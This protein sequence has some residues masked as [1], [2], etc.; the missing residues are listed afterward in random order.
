M[1]IP[2]TSAFLLVSRFHQQVSLYLVV[3]VFY[4]LL[5]K[6]VYLS[7]YIEFTRYIL[8]R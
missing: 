6:S 2:L 4:F 3:G 1:P 7:S 8:S 5:H